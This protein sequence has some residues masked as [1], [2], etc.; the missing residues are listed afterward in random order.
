MIENRIVADTE[1]GPMTTLVWRPDGDGPFPV[2]VC[3]HAGPGM[4][5]NIY[6]TARRFAEE[7]YY[8]A[9]PDLYHRYGE[10]ITFDFAQIMQPGSAENT[11]FYGIIDSTTPEVMAADTMALVEALKA[12]PAASDGPKGSIGFCHTTR[13]VIR[14][15]ADHPGDFPVGAIMHPAYTVTDAPDSPHRYVQRIQGDI[16]AGFG[17]VDTIAPLPEQQ[18]LIDEL[19]KLGDRA[20]VEIHAHGGHGFLWPGPFYDPDGAVSAWQKTLDIFGRGLKEPATA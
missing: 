5:E 20:V 13:A 9:V 7:G 12:E 16:Y 17:E 4:G 15:M 14:V 3:Y 6:A 11:R 19:G 8:A 18:P 2:V 1:G 10:L